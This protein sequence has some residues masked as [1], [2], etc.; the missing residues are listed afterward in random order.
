VSRD[1]EPL[2]RS[3]QISVARRDGYAL[4]RGD[5]QVQRV[6]GKQGQSRQGQPIPR[7]RIVRTRYRPS[8]V[9]PGIEMREEQALSTLRVGPPHLPPTYLPRNRGD[10]LYL[11]KVTDR[12]SWLPAEKPLDGKAERCRAVVGGQQARVD[13]DQERASRLAFRTSSLSGAPRT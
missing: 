10:E 4:R 1:G 5:R 12:Q 13:V 3:R 6:Q 2:R 9:H 7:R 8:R 11:H